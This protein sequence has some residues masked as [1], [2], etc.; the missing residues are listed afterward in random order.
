MITMLKNVLVVDGSGWFPFWG[1]VLLEDDKI[2]LIS[3]GENILI[4]EEKNYDRILNFKDGDYPGHKLPDAYLI[5][6]FEE[7]MT[8][9]KYQKELN[10]IIADLK[11]GMKIEASI[12][13]M[14]GFGAGQRDYLVNGGKANVAIIDSSVTKILMAFADGKEL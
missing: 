10:Q 5:P 1:D 13:K 8:M 9:E 12:R 6:G 11:S 2:K 14:T 7:D 4:R 3:C